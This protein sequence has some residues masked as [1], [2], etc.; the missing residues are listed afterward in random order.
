VSKAR[1]FE[2]E[3]AT[4]AGPVLFAFGQLGTAGRHPTID[5]RRGLRREHVIGPDL[6][7]RRN[8]K[9]ASRDESS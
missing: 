6:S 2:T 4:S 3:Y 5:R 1:R 9:E 7:N 8:Y